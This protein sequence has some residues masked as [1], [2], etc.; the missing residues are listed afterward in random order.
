VLL[1]PFFVIVNFL[2]HVASSLDFLAVLPV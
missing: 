1:V 2:L